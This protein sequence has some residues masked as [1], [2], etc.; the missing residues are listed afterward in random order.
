M[1]QYKETK[2]Y[3]IDQ[4]QQQLPN[5]LQIIETRGPDHPDAVAKCM[6]DG[7]IAIMGPGSANFATPALAQRGG[8]P[9]A[10]E[11]Y[12]KRLMPRLSS[13][14]ARRWSNMTKYALFLSSLM[15]VGRGYGVQVWSTGCWILY[16]LENS[17]T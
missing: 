10:V 14:L 8:L 6:A 5:R 17:T 11:R 2:D 12:G 3:G 15:G 4:P 16:R 1:L 13:K 9:Q 7:D